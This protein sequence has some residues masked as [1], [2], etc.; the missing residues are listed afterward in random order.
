MTGQDIQMNSQLDLVK[1][2][3]LHVLKSN[4]AVLHVNNEAHRIIFAF[5]HDVEET[6]QTVKVDDKW[7]DLN[8]WKESAGP[9]PE[10]KTYGA[11]IYACNDDGDGML[12]TI[13]SDLI[14]VPVEED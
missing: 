14:E 4:H 13:T 9:V 12:T 11:C 8:V 2:S 5:D 6:W 10:G 3:V 7:F 1:N